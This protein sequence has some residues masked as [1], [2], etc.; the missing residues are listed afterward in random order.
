MLC[1]ITALSASQSLNEAAMK[2]NKKKHQRLYL[3]HDLMFF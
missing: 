3:S 1:N 2:I